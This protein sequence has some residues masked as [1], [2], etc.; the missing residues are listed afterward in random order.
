[1]NEYEL[2]QARR[3]KKHQEAMRDP[4]YAAAYKVAQ[5]RK[6]ERER[7]EEILKSYAQNGFYHPP[8]QEEPKEKTAQEMRMNDIL[9]HFS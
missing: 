4:V 6:K 7:S 8:T 3:L 9:K 5:R 2:S 1:M